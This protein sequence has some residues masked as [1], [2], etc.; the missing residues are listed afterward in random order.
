MSTG[1]PAFRFRGRAFLAL[2]PAT[3]FDRRSSPGGLTVSS[4]SKCL[5]CGSP[6]PPVGDCPHC[7]QSA[8]AGAPSKTPS[9]LDQDL[10]LDRRQPSPGVAAHIPSFA[11]LAA[12][13]KPPSVAPVAPPSLP[14][15][16]RA[17]PAPVPN[18]PP[19]KPMPPPLRRTTPAPAIASDPGTPAF[20]TAAD[21]APAVAPL[22]TASPVNA[23]AGNAVAGESL[24]PATLFAAPNEASPTTSEPHPSSEAVPSSSSFPAPSLKEPSR[25]A[26]SGS[27]EEIHARPA[28]LWRRSVAFTVDAA[29]VLSVLALYLFAA[30]KIT[31]AQPPQ[32]Q[33][34]G[35]DGFVQ[36]LHA[37]EGILVPGL[38]LA[39]IVA[40]AYSIGFTILWQGRTIGRR[41]VGIRLVDKTGQAPKP[42]RTVVRALLSLVSAALFLGGF[43]LVLFDRR[44]QTLHDKLTATFVVQPSQPDRHQEVVAGGAP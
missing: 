44:R 20:V 22:S 1:R 40:L 6:L 35:V 31:G 42:P 34:P 11:E 36:R 25:P 27:V 21:E 39:V 28:A 12:N 23:L 3:A 37:F 43:W 32:A 5:K 24:E 41:L 17:A 7:A 2:A 15:A 9:L 16:S 30:A 13:M 33:L 26:G 8:A 29:V 14:V 38:I 18:F 4:V 10:H 19:A